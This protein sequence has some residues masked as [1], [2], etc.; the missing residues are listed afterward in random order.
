[1]TKVYELWYNIYIIRKEI[2]MDLID[3]AIEAIRKI[4]EDR[5]DELLEKLGQIS[6]KEKDD[7]L[8]ETS[9][10]VLEIV[11]PKEHSINDLIWRKRIAIRALSKADRLDQEIS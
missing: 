7:L 5:E 2:Y 1:L 9:E 11:F 4:Y 8:F 6:E 3:V 10:E